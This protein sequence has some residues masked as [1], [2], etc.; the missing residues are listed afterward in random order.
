L[1]NVK[2]MT[3]TSVAEVKGEDRVD[4]IVVE[5]LETKEKRE[6]RTDA[7]FVWI[8]VAP[9]TEWLAGA[10]ARDKQGFVLTGRDLRPQHLESWPENC[11]PGHLESSMRGV[12]VAGDVRHG[13]AKR[14]GSA[15][16][17]GAMAVH[18]IHGYLK[19]R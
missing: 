15:V 2:L 17:E 18:L 9:R 11:W 14:V 10:V 3:K 4:S 19:E 6:L 7:L 5:D 8:G 13:S 12:F 16:G 1:P